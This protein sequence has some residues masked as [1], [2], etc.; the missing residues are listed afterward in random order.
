ETIEIMPADLE[1][2]EES[3][4]EGVKLIPGQGPKE[5]IVENGKIK[6]L[7]LVKCE[8]VF[9]ENGR[10][11]PKFDFEKTMV[12]ETTLIIE[13]IG[14]SPD[15]SYIPEEFQNKMEFVRGKIKCGTYGETSL[16]WLFVGGDIKNGPDIV[17]G[18]ADGHNAAKGIDEYLRKSK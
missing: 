13:A 3:Q 1:E 15:Y 2:I 5:I 16:D 18:I 9:D 12:C 7:N 17:H 10:F 4:E 14:Q 11:N 6:S 8:S